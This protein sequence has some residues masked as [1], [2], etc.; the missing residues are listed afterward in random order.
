MPKNLEEELRFDAT[1]LYAEKTMLLKKKR[2]ILQ[3]QTEE[4]IIILIIILRAT[5]GRPCGE[6][7]Q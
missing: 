2:K 4:E 3:S 7:Q 5:T 1:V 6:E